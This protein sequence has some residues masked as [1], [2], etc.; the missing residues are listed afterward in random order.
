MTELDITQALRFLDMLDPSGRHV[1][2]SEAPFGRFGRE[3]KWEGGETFEA[4][5]R[6]L[7]IADIEKRQARESNV[8]YGVNAPC[9][10]PDQQG[11]RGKCGADDII[12]IRAL[13]FDVDFKVKRNPEL[14]GALLA[15]INGELTGPLCPSLLVDTG[16]GFQLIYLLKDVMSVQLFRPAKTSEQKDENE[17]IEI[18]RRAITQLAH[19]FE[20]LLRSKIPYEL[21]K[22]VKIDNM[23][24]VDRVM[25]LPGTVNY[26][27]QEK[28]DRGQVEALAHI[29]VDYQTKCDI[30]ALRK[31][32]PRIAVAPQSQVKK[33]YVPRP[34]DPW[35]PYAKAKFC[36]EFIRD[37]G[38][39]DSNEWYTR[40]VMLPLLGEVRAGNITLEQGEDL[41][42]EAVSGGARY[43]VDG[44]GINFFRRQWRSHLNS[45]RNGKMHLGSLIKACNDNG[46]KPPWSDTVKWEQDFHRQQK[47]LEE[48]KQTI[49]V[50]DL[51]YVKNQYR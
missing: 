45:S 39:A 14:D 9:S 6:H 41:F 3:P 33:P 38:L 4:Q 48:L 18:N 31:A 13:A 29:S 1:I 42:L 23:S 32:V 12:A 15:F 43:G 27:K 19:E 17:Q 10:A 47:E 34:N 7:L 30:Y 36:C 37:N 5:Q 44:R 49:D 28:L 26:P 8:Y 40:N 22:S 20:S 21:E 46:M 11:F 50:E 51:Q 24:N 2:A 25:R 16:G 35:T